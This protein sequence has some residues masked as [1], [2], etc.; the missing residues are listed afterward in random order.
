MSPHLRRPSRRAHRPAASVAA[1]RAPGR[2]RPPAPPLGLVLVITLTLGAC[3]SAA[4]GGTGNAATG[5]TSASGDTA[6]APAATTTTTEAYTSHGAGHDHS[7]VS[8]PDYPTGIVPATVR[9]PAIEVDAGTVSLDLTGEEPEVPADFG[10]TGWYEQTR[11]PGEIGPAVI[12]GHID[13]V[14]GPAVFARLDELAVGDEIEV[15]DASGE[16]RTF[17]VTGNGRYPKDALPDEVFGFDQA[18]PEL[19]L[20]TCGGSFDRSSGHY[21]D[22]FVVYAQAIVG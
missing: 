18:V 6:A 1:G 4:S 20:I 22:N 19:R 3:G 2:R 15:L 21:R 9:I 5:G 11:R 13:S 12:A 17:E 14:D 10:L 16:S 7:G 8:I